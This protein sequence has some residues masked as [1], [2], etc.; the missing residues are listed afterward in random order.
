VFTLLVLPPATA[1]R[2]TTRPVRGLLLAVVLGVATTWV[3]LGIA[4]YSPY[5]LGFWLS[6]LAFAEYVAAVAGSA[7]VS[8]LRQRALRPQLVAGS[9]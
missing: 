8:A 4:F 9:V 2:L 7:A 3:A 6:T 5:P 1:Q